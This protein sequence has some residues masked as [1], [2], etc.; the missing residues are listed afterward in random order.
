MSSLRMEIIK[1]N[2]NVYRDAWTLLLILQMIFVLIFTHSTRLFSERMCLL[3]NHNDIKRRGTKRNLLSHK[4][5]RCSARHSYL[6]CFFGNYLLPF[7]R[8]IKATL[9]Q[10]WTSDSNNSTFHK[11]MSGQILS[12]IS[13]ILTRSQEKIYVC[14]DTQPH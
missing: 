6:I 13:R 3:N 2:D 1:S 7:S 12:K 8:R 9:S 5:R 10:D 14:P 4:K 11:S